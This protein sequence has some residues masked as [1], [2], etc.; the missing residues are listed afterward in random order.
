M[1]CLTRLA[2]DRFRTDQTGD[3]V[4][5]GRIWQ[6]PVDRQP[7]PCGDQLAH[8]PAGVGVKAVPDQHDGAAE[9]LVG[10]VQEPGVARLGE[11]LARIAP[12]GAVRAVNQ[13]RPLPGPTAISAASD[14]R[15][16]CPPVTLTTGVRPRRPQGRPFGGLSPWPDSSSQQSQAPRSAAALL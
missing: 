11:P 3:R 7:V 12:P 2:S 4:Q 6:E 8:R 13:P 5:L 9:L 16:S 15:L 10:G 1:S 14:T